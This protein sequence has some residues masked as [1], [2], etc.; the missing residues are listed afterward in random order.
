MK[1]KKPLKWYF[2]KNA[3]DISWYLKAY[4]HIFFLYNYFLNKCRQTGFDLYGESLY[5]NVI[6]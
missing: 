3:C 6:N 1:N 5:T 4:F 2:F